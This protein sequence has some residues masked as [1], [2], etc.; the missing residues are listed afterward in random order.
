MSGR[1]GRKDRRTKKKDKEERK[2]LVELS[3]PVNT[4][5]ATVNP[6][7]A[8]QE[9]ILSTVIEH[10]V[11]ANAASTSGRNIYDD[12]SK[13]SSDHSN[14]EG[15]KIVPTTSKTQHQISSLITASIPFNLTI[16]D[17]DKLLTK[18]VDIWLGA[19][20]ANNDIQLMLKAKISRLM[21]IFDL[22]RRIA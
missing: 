3:M 8:I 9:E 7:D 6:K 19:G 18:V 2:L 13:E 4:R 16:V 22:W 20:S 5:S 1:R 21:K 14:L 11:T 10:I 17:F 12:S 15:K